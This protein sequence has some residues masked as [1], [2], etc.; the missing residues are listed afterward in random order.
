[1]SDT[2]RNIL[3]SNKG[4]ALLLAV[5]VM[6]LLVAVTVEFNKNMRQELVGSYTVKENSQLGAIMNSGYNIAEAVLFQ[7]TKDN[8]FDSGYD[9][10]AK[11]GSS[12]LSGLFGRGGLELIITDLSGKLQLNSLGISSATGDN[13]RKILTKLLLNGEFGDLSA[14]QVSLIVDAITDWVDTD[15]DPKGFEETESSFYESLDPPYSSKNGPFEFIEELLLVRGITRDLYFGSSE[16][17]GLRDYMTV[18]GNDGKININNA[19]VEILQ[20]MDENMA[21]ELVQEMVTFREDEGNKDLLKDKNW[22][23]EY[24]SEDL[25]FDADM[26]TTTSSYF[27]IT[28]VAKYVE[29]QRTLNAVVKRDVD[30]TVSLISRKVE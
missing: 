10:W 29:M 8:A 27:D 22:Y 3:K 1:M 12:N 18:H 20:A 4:M 19:P 24:V 11:L 23:I 25:K 13:G 21:E 14:D 17:K 9:R 15:D 30:G 16:Y 26:V 7:D 2:G 6:S 28:A 5:S